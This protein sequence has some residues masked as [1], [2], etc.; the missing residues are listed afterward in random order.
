ML[1]K[2]MI[3][4]YPK[5]Y[6]AVAYVKKGVDNLI[7][8]ATVIKVYPT[9]RHAYESIAE[10]KSFMSRYNDFDI[11]YGDYNDY[12]ST[13]RKIF[14]VPDKETLTQDEIDNLIALLELSEKGG[15]M[16]SPMS[17]DV[18]DVGCK[19]LYINVNPNE[20]WVPTRLDISNV[21]D[22][23]SGDKNET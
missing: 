5:Q 11:V 14:V 2:E 18:L 3:N 16:V 19:P 23:L 12:V 6:I 4:K 13:R 21:L 8:T 17:V 9:L 22:A 10:I 1:L 15:E 20:C 7:Q